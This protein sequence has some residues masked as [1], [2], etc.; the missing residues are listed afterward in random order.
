MKSLRCILCLI[1]CVAACLATSTTTSTSN[2][3]PYKTLGLQKEASQDEIRSAY[4]KLCLKYHPDKNGSKNSREKK[5]YEELFKE[6]QTANGLIGDEEARRNYDLRSRFSPYSSYSPFGTTTTTTT[7]AA[8]S[9]GQHSFPRHQF[10]DESVDAFY[11]AFASAAAANAGS[12]RTSTTNPLFSSFTSDN[13]FPRSGFGKPP[14][15][16][17]GGSLKTAYVQKVKVPLQDLYN[18]RSAMEFHLE[19]SLWKRYSATFRGGFGYLLLYQSLIFSAPLLRLNR[20][21]ALAFSAFVFHRHVPR[22]ST[23]QYTANIQ[24]GYKEGTK[25][26]FRDAEPG[27]DV[28]FL[29]EEDHH[30]RFE[31]VG[32]DLHTTVE[33]LATQARDGC[34]VEVESL[35]PSEKPTLVKLVPN[36]IKQ[37]GDVLHV[38]AAGWPIRKTGNRGDLVI[39]FKIVHKLDQKKNKKRGKKKK[40]TIRQPN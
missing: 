24:P 12:R 14:M 22:P 32:N 40:T 39:K 26:T 37:T 15:F 34:T 23:L 21:V 17:T 11:R 5:K 35:N 1:V 27:F 20:W 33:I 7:A 9:R 8:A 30:D 16:W 28:T 31:R 18:G 2:I 38:K 3:D 10:R 13:L 6:I 4:R 25:I 29:V 36:Q 19:D